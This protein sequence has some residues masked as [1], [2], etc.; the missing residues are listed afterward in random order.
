MSITRLH[1][2]LDLTDT[3]N[4][5]FNVPELLARFKKRSLR[6]AAA[7]SKGSTETAGAD[8][9]T[10]PAMVDPTETG[11][12]I[13]KQ[14]SS[15]DA[16]D[17]DAE[18]GDNAADEEGTH[19]ANDDQ[20]N[21]HD[22]SADDSGEGGDTDSSS[23]DGD[24][25]EEQPKQRVRQKR[26]DPTNVYDI[27]DDF[28]DDSELMSAGI[29]ARS[30]RLAN[31]LATLG[32]F[33][34]KGGFEPLT[35]E[36]PFKDHFEVHR[37]PA[38][39]PKR[40][41]RLSFP[42]SEKPAKERQQKKIAV[43]PSPLK[44]AGPAAPNTDSGPPSP[45]RGSQ[46]L[47]ATAQDGSSNAGPPAKRKRAATA[48][49]GLKSVV[50]S[51]TGH[52]GKD[53]EQAP[54]ASEQPKKKRVS[55]GGAQS[56]AGT[57]ASSVSA[58]AANSSSTNPAGNVQAGSTED[59]GEDADDKR[60]GKKAPLSTAVDITM[61][62]LKQERKKESFDDKK[63]FPEKLR[64]PLLECCKTAVQHDELD[65]NFVR[66]L[67]KVL[68]YNSFTLRRLVGRTMLNY[69]LM[70][71]KVGLELKTAEFH[72][73][74]DT[75]CQQQGIDG[76]QDP[77]N[78]SDHQQSNPGPESISSLTVVPERKKF[79]F[80][81]ELKVVLWNLLVMEWEQVELKHLLD[82]LE[83]GGGSVSNEG[84]SGGS[85]PNVVKLTDASVR[86]SVYAK[87]VPFWPSGWMSSNDIS[88]EYSLFKRRINLRAAA[89]GATATVDISNLSNL[90]IVDGVASVCTAVDT[91]EVFRIL[92]AMKA[93]FV[94]A[95]PPAASTNVAPVVKS[96]DG[97]VEKEALA[98]TDDGKAISGEADA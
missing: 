73:L 4:N 70:K 8:A 6:A 75:L 76:P 43:D 86:K 15:D 84:G 1:L 54:G 56:V 50:A 29:P 24:E 92:K 97:A 40:M 37:S 33:V 91:R 23:S 67:K 20:V 82:V 61:K 17:D 12:D 39:K 96:E 63:T 13:D 18:D 57:A 78:N 68:P 46:P 88:R 10:D 42:S 77:A 74:V 62:Y 64:P 85:G 32:F 47:P 69:G 80:N 51:A 41:G 79:R 36:I 59:A 87:L 27:E 60:K 98:V 3:R 2:P 34:W 94:P 81:E 55:T 22:A 93:M 31:N 72:G 95:A 28:I 14:A 48:A 19:K 26:T 38:Q 52:S 66:H 21:G 9:A 35:K 44:P 30:T 25:D 49:S 58:S 65:E 83:A 45:A 16:D 71:A 90:Y 5:V 7:K 11:M 89:A 53:G